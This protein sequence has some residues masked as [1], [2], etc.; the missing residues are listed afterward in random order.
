MALKT[1]YAP[2]EEL[3]A[4]D[5]NA[6]NEQVN[7][8]EAAIAALSGGVELEGTTT[9]ATPTELESGVAIDASSVSEFD[10]QVVAGDNVS[11]KGWN[12]KGTIKRDGAGNTALG[13]SVKKTSFGEDDLAADW[14]V[15]VTA[16]DTEET[17][18]VTVTGEAVTTIKWKA[19][20]SISKITF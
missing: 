16:D 1:D 5:V 11:S 10:I 13:G 7:A 18:V 17:L 6:A 9:D 3:P 14:D 2:N 8:N 19:S 20:I 4:A 15:N 12:F